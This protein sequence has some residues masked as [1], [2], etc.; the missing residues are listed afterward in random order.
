MPPSLYLL[1]A[2]A[3]S[4]LQ[5]LENLAADLSSYN[6]DVAVITETHF[7]LKQS[8][9]AVAIDGYTIFRRDR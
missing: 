2:A 3:L 5:A 4:K 1:D 6:I 8:N 7:K 9:T